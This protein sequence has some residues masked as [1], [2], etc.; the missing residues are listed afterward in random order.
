MENILEIKNLHVH[1]VTEDN[2]IKA[3]NGVNLEIKKGDSLGLVGETGAG[4]TTT[5]LSIIQLIPDPPGM[6]VDGEILYKGKNLIHN[7]EKEN[8]QLRGNGISMIFQDSM[9]A[10]NPIMRVGDQLAEVLITHKKVSKHEARNQVV[11]LL[12]TV[13][14]KADRYNDYPHQF[15]GGMKQRVLITMALLCNPALLI[16]DEPTTALDVT[17]QAQVLEL[18]KQ[19]RKQYDMSMLFIS[20]DLGVVAETCDR[21]AI[22]Y[23]GEIV[24]IGTVEEVYTAPKHPYTRGL[25]QSIP[26][27]EEDRAK[28]FQ[29][30]GSM[31]NPASLPEGCFFHPRCKHKADICESISPTMQGERHLSKCHFS[32]L[33]EVKV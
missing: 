31:A 18:M 25:F 20:H 11:D 14:V 22:M 13:G 9:T 26:K 24:E 12:E 7:T 8:K 6:I 1:Y 27:L 21:V 17:I 29:I 4:K 19:L 5:A 16:A 32:L 15:S 23:A 28:L 2:V 10:L 33:D 30:E 3:V